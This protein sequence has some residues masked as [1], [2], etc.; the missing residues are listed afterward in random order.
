MFRIKHYWSQKNESIYHIGVRKRKYLPHWSQKTKISTT[1]ESEKR[2]YLPHWSQKTK[3]STTFMMMRLWCLGHRCKSA[4]AKFHWGSL[5]N[6][7][8]SIQFTY[9]GNQKPL[10]VYLSNSVQMNVKQDLCE[11]RK[12]VFNIS[13]VNNY[14]L[15][16]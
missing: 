6:T 15:R 4:K 12:E 1:L 9:H 8:C 14:F 16:K 11:P 5:I 13:R 10:C 3:V 2:K 7:Q